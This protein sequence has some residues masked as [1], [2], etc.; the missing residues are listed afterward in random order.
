[1]LRR[2]KKLGKYALAYA[3]DRIEGRKAVKA[4]IQKVREENKS[5]FYEARYRYASYFDE[6][7]LQENLI[8]A[9]SQ[10]GMDLASGML[11]L[12]KTLATTPEYASYEIRLVCHGR[13]KDAIEKLLKKQGL[14]QIETVVLSSDEYFKILATAKYLLDDKAIP[15]WWMKKEGQKYL[16]ICQSMP[17]E[18]LGRKMKEN[19]AEIGNMQK[20][21]FAADYLFF[22]NKTAMECVLSDLM[23]NNLAKGK[24]IL[25]AAP[26]NGVFAGQEAAERVRKELMVED[27]RVYMYLPVFRGNTVKGKLAKNDTFIVYYLYWLDKQLGEDEVLFVRLHSVVQELVDFKELTHVRNLP[28]EYGLY[29]F[30]NATD[31]L[32]TDYSDVLFDYPRTGK[33]QI[34]FTYDLE[35]F[36]REKGLYTDMESLPFPKVQTPEELLLE[37]R[38]GK[39]YDDTAFLREYCCGETTG[40]AKT[41]CDAFFKEDFSGV[42]VCEIPDNGKKNVLIYLGNL[43]RNGIT[44]SAKNLFEGLDTSEHNYFVA[45]SSNRIKGNEVVLKELPEQISYIGMAGYMQVTLDECFERFRF[46][47]RQISLKRYLKKNG[48]RIRQEWKRVFADIRLD[49]IVQFNGYDT[50]MT[51]LFSMFE[52]NSVIFVHNDMIQEIRTRRNQRKDV[53]SYAYRNYGKVAVVT[54]DLIPSTASFI[55]G[56]T[57]RIQVCRNRIDVNHILTHA[58]KME[59]AMTAE[60]VYPSQIALKGVFQ[61]EKKKFISLGRFSPEKGHFRLLSAFARI[62]AKNPDTMLV[63]A[64]GVALEQYFRRTVRCVEKLGLTDCVVLVRNMPNPF[65]LLKACDYFVLSSFYEGFGLVI[66]EADVLGKPIACTDVVGP[67]GFLKQHGGMLVEDSENGIYEGMKK[68]LEGSVPVMNVDYTRYNEEAMQEFYSLL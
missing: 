68:L 47:E 67:R 17:V 37:L 26:Q 61:S 48:H 36:E 56:N 4:R 11:E 23:I 52:G 38:S 19:F 57:E 59:N 63:I 39:E 9:E 29:E 62:H 60:E 30:L 27:K 12:L 64:G 42:T 55:G 14:N 50:E 33:K 43:A 40:A 22:P 18:Y 16:N 32:V 35:E 2:V 25:G 6:L 46:I 34:L 51:L 1:M 3:E 53:L 58:D 31:V 65:P 49:T 20:N 7:P 28:E 41:L 66:A 54:E 15:A 10:F 8:M 21:C 24:C 45:F 13:K 5:A 44:R